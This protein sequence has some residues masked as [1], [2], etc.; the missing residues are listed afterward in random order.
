MRGELRQQSGLPDAR[1]SG[2]EQD[3]TAIRRVPERAGQCRQLAAP[4]HQRRRGHA[5]L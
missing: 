4:T 1:V 5:G 3:A 2:E